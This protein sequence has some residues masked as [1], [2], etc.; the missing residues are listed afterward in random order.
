MQLAII[1]PVSGLKQFSSLG[2]MDM[3]LT[4]LVL[5]ND[6][7][8]EFYLNRSKQK[9]FLMLDNS[10]CE[11]EYTD[12]GQG[13]SP[14]YVLEAAKKIEA[15]ELIC[16]DVLYEK[17]ETIA[18]TN[19]F[20]SF[21]KKKNEIGNYSL[22]AVPQG[23]T[24]DE[25]LDCYL[26]FAKYPEINT[27]GLS[28]LSVPVSFLSKDKESL[29]VTE[30]RKLCIQK[31]IDENICPSVFDKQIH[32]LGGDDGTPNELRFQHIYKWV[33][34]CDT[35]SPTWYGTQGVTFSVVTG[36]AQSFVGDKPD[37]YGHK[38]DTEINLSTNAAI[39]YRNISVFFK[40]MTLP[41][42][43]DIINTNE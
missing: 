10:A 37:L 40:F 5:S 30:G 35:S 12:K 31:L 13:W 33:R 8:A 1:S 28:K 24:V 11:M 16:T 21:L 22:M 25:W 38:E 43:V 39:I 29:C 34:S 20:I 19:D 9:Y 4:H 6:E 3:A 15:T 26:A 7:Y 36:I 27:I 41:L 17:D 2:N 32:L 14:E 42:N 18:C 23:R